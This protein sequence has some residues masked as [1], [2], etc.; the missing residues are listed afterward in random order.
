MEP[1]PP[2]GWVEAPLPL[3]TDVQECRE[4]AKQPHVSYESHSAIGLNSG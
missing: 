1:W 4:R 3:N 2:E